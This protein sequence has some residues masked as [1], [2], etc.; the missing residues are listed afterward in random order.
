MNITIDKQLLNIYPSLSLGCLFYDAIV[1]KT[2]QSL[3]KTL[4]NETFPTLLSK[5]EN[6]SITEIMGIHSSRKAYKAF[7]KDPSRYR[8]SSESLIRRIKQ[9]KGLY[10]VNTVVDVN[11]LISIETGLSVGS[12]DV[13]KIEENI[14]LTLGKEN[15]GYVGIGKDFINMENL[16]LL[17]DKKGAFGSPTS[18]SRRTMITESSTKILTVIYCFSDDMDLDAILKKSEQELSEYAFA[19]NIQT[20]IIR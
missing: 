20:Q 1:Q 8:V 5:L 3:W 2:N 4:E 19:K 18:D 9:K 12:Y 13:E 16:L 10:H 14:T 7:G 11:N 15:E 6:A 17:S